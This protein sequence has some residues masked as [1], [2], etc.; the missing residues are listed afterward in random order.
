[1]NYYELYDTETYN[2]VLKT[3]DTGGSIF[4]FIHEYDFERYINIVINPSYIDNGGYFLY[5]FNINDNSF[6]IIFPS[7][8]YDIND[9]YIPQ[10]IAIVNPPSL[11]DDGGLPEVS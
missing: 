11:D 3:F 2:N 7:N 4:G 1:M 9:L 5:F 8:E 6:Y 10:N